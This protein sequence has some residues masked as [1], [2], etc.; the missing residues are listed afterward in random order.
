[1]FDAPPPE[2]PPDDL[3]AAVAGLPEL[4]LAGDAAARLAAARAYLAAGQ[5]WI[6][7]RHDAGAAGR[8]VV[9]LHSALLDRLLAAAFAAEGAG[10]PPMALVALGGYGRSELAPHS[11]VDLLFLHG[12]AGPPDW[13]V[14]RAAE[15]ILYLLWDTGLDVGHAVRSTAECL[16]IAEADHTARTALIDCRLVAGDVPLYRDFESAML[17]Q[18]HSQRVEGFIRDKA[19]EWQARHDRFGDT[20]YRLEPDVKHGEGGLR[21]LHSALWIARACYHVAGL[22]DLG[23]RMLL[24][25]REVAEVRAARDFLW[26]VR[27]GLHYRAGRQEDH[28]TFDAQEELA[29]ALGYQDTGG[30][31]GVERFM[32]AYYLSARTVLRV[33]RHIIERC[34]EE[35]RAGPFTPAS[36]R[37][38]APGFVVFQGRLTV[39]DRGRLEADP[40]ALVAVFGV[41]DRE[42]L[43]LHS[44]TRDLVR[45]AAA[46]LDGAGRSDPRVAAAF[47]SLFEREGTRGAFLHLMHETGVL[48]ALVPEFGRQTGLWQ[49]DLY[50]TYTV[51]VHSLFAVQRLMKLRAGDLPDPVFTPRM[52]ALERPYALYLGTWFHDIGKGL[53]GGHADKGA[54]MIPEIARRLH[55]SDEEADEVGFLVRTHL[56][57][58]HISQRRDLADPELV[59]AFADEVGSLRRLTM[60]YLLTFADVGTTGENT[61]TDWKAMLLTELYEKTRAVLEDRA[62]G[63]EQAPPAVEERAREGAETLEARLVAGYPREVV[64][65]F[66][67]RLP[68]RYLATVPPEKAASHLALLNRQARKGP[69][70]ARRI[71]HPKKG[72]TE[73]TVAAPDRPGLLADLT[74][75]LSA[76][77]VDILGAEIFSLDDGRILD[78]FLVRDRRGGILRSGWDALR[79]EVTKAALTPGYGGELVARRLRPGTLKPRPAPAVPVK[80]QVDNAASAAET[81]VDVFA[82]D[83]RGLLHTITRT[84][85]EL[86]LQVVLARVATEAHRATDAFY[87]TGPEGGKVTDPKVL[88]ALEHALTEA[89]EA[90]DRRAGDAPAPPPPGS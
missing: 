38:V 40:A 53:G 60:L 28:L 64:D 39:E 80:V 30:E 34:T 71:H 84:L 74:G 3:D 45:E 36:R 65:Q 10:A 79:R 75:A 59:T 47:R 35:R 4:T 37:V 15:A 43:P 46:G 87:V 52:Q 82:R 61:W 13:S 44:F 21:D 83:R 78:V 85:H 90:D 5:A 1:M 67:G 27:S 19:G 7:A 26:R 32:R 69:V 11:D 76:G 12:G 86:G 54:A 9:R 23:R 66:V 88:G 58:S 72:Y 68:E 63:R 6:R 17:G 25:P 24:P 51:D 20:V 33:S 18:I 73:L 55:L 77:R 31:L 2:P 70:V 8:T 29:R 22:S 81:V 89:I 41:A 16:E 57:M 56:R 14:T 62:A 42:G 48:G 50:H 49:H